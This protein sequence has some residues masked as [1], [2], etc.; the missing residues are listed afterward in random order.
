MSHLQRHIDYRAD[1]KVETI[2]RETRTADVVVAGFPKQ[3]VVG[4]IDV[5][6]ALL[7]EGGVR[8]AAVAFE[9]YVFVI[10]VGGGCVRGK[11]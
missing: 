8:T 7:I 11:E 1:W 3:G 9:E 5:Q 4:E 2:Q 6:A 10:V